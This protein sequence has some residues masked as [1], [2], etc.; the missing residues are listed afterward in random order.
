MF[1]MQHFSITF[2]LIWDYPTALLPNDESDVSEQS[3]LKARLLF[4]LL[5]RLEPL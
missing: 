3:L 2:G 4:L 5:E 1:T